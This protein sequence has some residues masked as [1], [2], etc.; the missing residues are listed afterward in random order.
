MYDHHQYKELRNF[1][2]FSIEFPVEIIGWSNQA[3]KFS[4]FAEMS[5]ISDNG[6]CFSTTNSDW[7]SISQQLT[8]NVHLPETGLL[9]SG[10]ECQAS[11]MWMHYID[12]QCSETKDQTLIG[13]CLESLMTFETQKLKE[14]AKA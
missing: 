9:N 12:Q 8:V 6:L 11:V 10:I 5:N 1:K 7:Y 3:E 13:L 2:R 4:D 14:F